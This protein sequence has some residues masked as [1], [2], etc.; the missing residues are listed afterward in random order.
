LGEYI[1]QGQKSIG[2]SVFIVVILVIVAIIVDTSIT[3]LATS[4]GGLRSSVLDIALFAFMVFV[5]GIGQYIVMRFVRQEYKDRSRSSIGKDTVAGFRPGLNV[6]DRVVTISQYSLLVILGFVILQ[7]IL[8]NSYHILIL[9]AAIIISYGLTSI[10]LGLLSIRFF[11]WFRSNRNVVVLAYAC[12]IFMISINAAVTIVYSNNE[13]A[14]DP[15][16]IRPVRSL[17]GAYTSTE[18]ALSSIYVISSVL[19][20]LLAWIATVLLLR[21]Y[22]RKLGRTKYWIIVSIPLGYF[23][24]QFQPLFLYSFAELRISDPVL[25]GIIYNLIFSA[26]NPAG[27]VLFG[28]AFWTLSRRLTSKTVKT[29]M[30]ISAYGMTLLFAANQPTSL[31]LIPY[32]PFGLTSICFMILAAY[33][34]FLGIYSSSISVAEDS[35]LRQSIRK[36]AFKELQFLDVI[37]T[38]EMERE[39]VRKVIPMFAMA[40]DNMVKETGISSSLDEDDLKSYLQEVLEEVKNKGK[41]S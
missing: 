30:I 4:A 13:F 24:S 7:M 1:L 39:I 12:A 11:S 41:H 16:Y 26:S 25:F 14:N 19:S 22:S 36:I 37:G 32:P 9:K 20:F 10:I 5:F 6:L 29:Y 23:L 34:V 28:I 8:I 35:R 31:I 33:L 18:N 38:A 17:T 3:N 40:K 15:A 27:G 2:T 21:H